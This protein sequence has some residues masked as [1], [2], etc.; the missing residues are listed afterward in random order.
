MTNDS[1]TL[2]RA[3]DCDIILSRNEMQEKW[4]NTISKVHFRIY[5]EC[6]NNSNETLIFLEDKSQ[7]GTFVNKV[8]VGRGNRVILENNSEI[9]ISITSLHSN[10]TSTE[11]YYKLLN[12]TEI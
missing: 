2:G 6:I 12:I 7:N 9:A 8:K 11:I 4:L 5:R 1:Y 3:E 10:I